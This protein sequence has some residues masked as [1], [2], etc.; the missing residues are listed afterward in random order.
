MIRPELL[1]L[2]RCPETHQRLSLAPPEILD[3]LNA[4]AHA[5]QLQ[6]RAGQ[7]IREP[8]EAALL[9]ED[10]RFVYPIRSRLP[11]MLIPEALPTD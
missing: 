8:L 3:A 7:L 10:R 4:K 1:E 6:N 2:L 5:G 9:R 11:I